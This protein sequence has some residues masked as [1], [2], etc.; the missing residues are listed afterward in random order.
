MIEVCGVKAAA[1]RS[2]DGIRGAET[3]EY[4]TDVTSVTIEGYR[5]VPYQVD[6]DYLGETELLEFRHHPDAIRL[7]MPGVTA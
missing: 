5:P 6:G 4:R 3:V 2:E 7:V 1:L